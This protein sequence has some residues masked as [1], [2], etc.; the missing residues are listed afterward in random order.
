MTLSAYISAFVSTDSRDTVAQARLSEL[1]QK[2]VALTKLLTRFTGWVAPLDIQ[3]LSEKSEVVRQHAYLLHLF[4]ERSQHLMSPAEENLAAELEPSSGTAWRQLHDNLCSQI[5]VPLETEAGIQDL[6]MSSIRNLAM[7]PDR[8]VRRRAF[9]AE[10]QAWERHALPLAAA[11]NSIKGETNVLSARRKWSAPL[12]AALFENH[13]D[14]ATLEAMLRAA[15]ESFPDFRRYLRAKARLLGVESLAWYDVVAPVGSD[16]REWSY[17]AAT[18]FIVEQF[19]SYSSRLSEFA[20]RAFRENWIDAEPRP[21]KRDGAFCMKLRNDESRVLANFSPTFDGM[22]TL[23]HELGHAYHNLN[24]GQKPP[25][26]RTAPMTLAETAS[27][28]CQ[29][30]VKEAVLKVA[31]TDEQIS[32]LEAS[33]QDQC[34]VVVDIT[35]RFLFEERLLEARSRRELSVEEL[36]QLMLDAQKET[37]GD[38]LDPSLLHP[39]M[40]AVKGH[41][42]SVSRA[43]YNYPYMFGLLFGLGLYAVYQRDPA[44]FESSYDDMLA[45]TGEADPASLAGR[46]GIDIRSEQFWR[47]SLDIVRADIDRFEKLASGQ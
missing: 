12:D 40:W 29:T 30:L 28:F 24:Q 36:N 42:Y 9:E 37:Y 19:G 7:N 35:S 45:S 41:Y 15:R 5:M 11:L 33:L 39:Y 6:P 20:Q 8:D 38:A 3:S 26:L 17:P 43:F 31:S 21:G 4:K 44:M 10:I 16:E 25:L 34:G 1:S 27:I 32:I 46:F 14:R 2:S 23:A 22:S 18:S 13:I 47:S